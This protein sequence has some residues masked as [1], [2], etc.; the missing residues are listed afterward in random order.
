M[1]MP[2]ELKLVGT[3]SSPRGRSLTAS[4]SFEPGELIAQFA[5]PCIVLPDSPSL[6]VTCSHC[7]RTDTAVRAC[8][9]CRSTY[10]CST[11][12][13]KSDWSEAHK[14]E[15]K[16]FKKV[17][18]EG[19]DV[20]PTPVRALVQ[21]LLRPDM[22]AAAAEMEGHVEAFKRNEPEWRDMQLQAMASL[23]YL[24]R[25]AAQKRVREAIE[26]LCKLQVNSF[27]RKDEDVG[28][29]GIFFN[30]ALSM[31]N[32]S[33][34]PNAHVQFSGRKAILRANTA[35]EEGAEVDISYIDCNLHRSHRQRAL[36]ERWHFGCACPRCR[37]DLDVYQVARLYPSIKC[38]FLSLNA[39]LKPPQ[40]PSASLADK[41]I[42]AV[43]E[44]IY[45]ACSTPPSASGLPNYL[46]Q[47]FR[48]RWQLCEPLRRA[49]L[50]A[51]EPLPQVMGEATLYF[52]ERG[53]FPNSLAV[54]CFLAIYSD[55][56]K[57]PMPFGPSRVKGLLMLA[58]ILSNTAPMSGSSMPS[59][60]GSLD[61]RVAQALSKMDQ[62]TM[63]QAILT[64]VVHW[65][66]SAHSEDWQI[67]KEA[68]MQLRD[69]ENLPGREKEKSLI[70]AWA[71]HQD[72]PEAA[73]F[74]EVAVLKPIRELAGFALEIMD[75]HFGTRQ[76]L[77]A[78]K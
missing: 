47:I 77:L 38:T 22:K 48:E 54:S 12:C 6:Q 44:K 52:G 45:L 20:L 73:M 34:L 7:L 56:F 40:E 46:D 37:D 18:A 72:N 58:N 17:K 75:S 21:M 36:K 28:Q 64:I 35:I 41:E 9:G 8:T 49:N 42:K 69:I 78:N 70:Q 59:H 3:P 15:C 51:I 26:L 14:A 66:A 39:D 74:Y 1:D 67:H 68:S 76:G 29:T 19:H 60:G 4:R 55:P 71:K 33:C 25:E 53:A 11:P 62:A 10:Y 5:T 23:H 31:V 2:P 24:G 63:A 32:H 27:N 43:V 30:P 50:F 57:S 65:A 61:G 13:Q 16:V